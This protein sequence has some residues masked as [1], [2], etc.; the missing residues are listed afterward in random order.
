[1]EKDIFIHPNALVESEQIG[2]GTRIWAFAHVLKGA[3]IG[4]NC[5]IGDHC[6][7]EEGVRIGNDVVVKNGVS[8]WE[9]I[10]IEDR[11][12]V[13]PN[14]AFTND[15]APRA[16][17][18]RDEYDKVVV[19]EGASLGANATIVSPRV[20]GRYAMVGAGSV[21]TRD[22]PDF[23]LVYGNPAAHAGWVCR[24]G[25]RVEQRSDTNTMVCVVCGMIYLKA[26]LQI[27]PMK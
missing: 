14:A 23:A 27:T 1:M 10:V 6:F 24:C 11:V 5:N 8:L 13:G 7:I 3:V 20:I 12:F 15:R 25:G 26:G 19:K 21:V 22:V 9:G 18:F 17:V 16:K 4:K 2:E